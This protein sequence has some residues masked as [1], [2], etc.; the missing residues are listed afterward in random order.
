MLNELI[1]AY[2][3]ARNNANLKEMV[4]IEKELNKAGMNSMTIRNRVREMAVEKKG[5]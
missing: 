1:E 4:R 3:D 2:I 5:A